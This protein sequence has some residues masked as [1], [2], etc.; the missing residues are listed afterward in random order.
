MVKRSAKS[1]SEDPQSSMNIAPATMAMGLGGVKMLHNPSVGNYHD[2]HVG[3]SNII[4]STTEFPT[5]RTAMKGI[6]ETSVPA[7]K[8]SGIHSAKP[9]ATPHALGMRHISGTTY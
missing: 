6:I 1:R 3:I 2:R 7:H 5:V 4:Q 8:Q 9:T